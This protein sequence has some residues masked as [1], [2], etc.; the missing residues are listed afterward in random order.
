MCGLTGFITR[1][2]DRGEFDATARGMAARLQHRGPDDEGV[3]VDADAGI[4]L[5]HRRLSILDLSAAGHQPM[6]SASDRWVLVYNGE[7]YNHLALRQMLDAQQAAP[8]WRGHSDTETLLACIEAWGVESTLQAAVGMFAI[9]LWD[10]GERA[11]W[12]AR[13]R[14]G[15][16]PMYYGW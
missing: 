7:I 4:A 15:E 13:D 5:A 8:A 3:W 9:A 14:M 10:R 16:K 11:L 6:A 12:L 2:P 1:S